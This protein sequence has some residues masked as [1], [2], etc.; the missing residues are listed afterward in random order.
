MVGVAVCAGWLFNVTLAAGD[1]QPL[2]FLA[3]RLYVAATGY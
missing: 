3:V 1:I 2:S